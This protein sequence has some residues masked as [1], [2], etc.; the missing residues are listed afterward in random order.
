MTCKDCIHYDVCGYR[1]IENPKECNETISDLNDIEKLCESF[2]DKSLYIELPCKV[3]DTVYE[4]T[5]RGINTYKIVRINISKHGR[6]FEWECV[7][8]FYTSLIGF[9]D[10]EIGET[11]FLTKEKAEAKLKELKENDN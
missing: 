2:K 4:P 9:V 1:N 8:G 7:D 10:Y 3:G 5:R 11:V 6:T